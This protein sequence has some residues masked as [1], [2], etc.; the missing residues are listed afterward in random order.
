MDS[1]EEEEVFEVESII[2]H[3][4]VDGRMQYLLRWRAFGDEEASWEF[5]EDMDCGELLDE[6]KKTVVLSDAKSCEPEDD[7]LSGF[8]AI[9]T[10]KPKLVI[11]AFKDGDRLFYRV[12][13]SK[14]KFY[15]IEADALRAV[16]PELICIFLENKIK[17]KE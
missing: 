14:G 3:R 5:E 6:Y 10:R 9:Q 4:I 16:C 17:L 13:C 8:D 2:G 1:P 15:N 11:S 7:C 12:A